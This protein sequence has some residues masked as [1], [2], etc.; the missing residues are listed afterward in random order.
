MVN[1]IG[2]VGRGPLPSGSPRQQIAQ[3]NQEAG[4]AARD[5]APG[6]LKSFSS[7]TSRIRELQDAI[8]QDPGAGEGRN[9]RLT[10]LHETIARYQVTLSNLVS[11]PDEDFVLPE[12]AQ[13]LR[14]DASSI[15]FQAGS[16]DA[17]R[18]SILELLDPE[19]L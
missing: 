18:Q 5:V 10:E 11:A 19:T 3:Q 12:V 2:P 6:L 8:Q 17:D 9:D 14:L 4:Q 1:Q 13:Q 15:A 16:L 7:I